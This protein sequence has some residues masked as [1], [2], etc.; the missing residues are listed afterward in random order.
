MQLS[1]LNWRP[2]GGWRPGAGRKRTSRRMPHVSR[3]VRRNGVFHV[4]ARIRPGLP[5]LR[6]A[7]VVQR[8]EQS[9]RLGCSREDFR[10][11]HYSLQRDH[12]H[13]LVEA[14]DGRSLG[15][16]VRSLLI[17]VTRAANAIWG[18][19]GA[20]I[21]DRYHHRRL[22][23]P[24]EVHNA[25]AYVFHNAHKHLNLT[26]RGWVDPASSGRWFWDL[27]REVPAVAPARYWLL[28]VGWRRHAPIGVD[29][30]SG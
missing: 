14:A 1:L 3:D 27:A 15:R 28:R 10:L 22:A 16:G 24:H 29:P 30:E 21:G 6:A 9:F 25:L 20:V 18:R 5:S 2:R 12:L 4:T 7:R 19:R 11:V 23:T 8:V 26:V 17:R 13:L